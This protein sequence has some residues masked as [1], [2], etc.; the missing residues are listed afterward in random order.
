LFNSE[1]KKEERDLWG[2]YCPLYL[3]VYIVVITVE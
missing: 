2:L 1:Q 3:L